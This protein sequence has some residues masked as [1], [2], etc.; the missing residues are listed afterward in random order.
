MK[1]LTWGN[2]IYNLFIVR[3]F[4]NI[5]KIVYHWVYWCIMF[6]FILKIRLIGQWVIIVGC[7]HSQMSQ[8]ACQTIKKK[9]QFCYQYLCGATLMSC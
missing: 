3:Y 2:I 6:S 4:C 7:D 8:K 1:V 9:L 5:Q